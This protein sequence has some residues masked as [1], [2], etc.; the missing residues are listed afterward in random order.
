MISKSQVVKVRVLLVSDLEYCQRVKHGCVLL[1]IYK[2]DGQICLPPGFDRNWLSFKCTARRLAG[3]ETYW[4]W[5]F[6]IYGPRGPGRLKCLIGQLAA[7]IKLA[8]ILVDW[9]GA[10]FKNKAGRPV[11]DLSGS[12]WLA[13]RTSCGKQSKPVSLGCW[14]GRLGVG[15]VIKKGDIL[16]TYGHHR[17]LVNHRSLGNR[18]QFI[19]SLYIFN[20]I[21]GSLRLVLNGRDEWFGFRVR[22]IIIE[23]EYIMVG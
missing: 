23:F 15:F 9:L 17:L 21:F 4:P 3:L 16:Q 19:R 5:P 2:S 18:S 20:I 11:Q 22:R 13:G 1:V 10:D 14:H 6:T 8:W 7:M 12:A